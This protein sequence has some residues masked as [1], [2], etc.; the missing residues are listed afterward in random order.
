MKDY[1][2]PVDRFLAA[3]TEAQERARSHAE[4]L[5]PMTPSE[6]AIPRQAQQAMYDQ[7]YRPLL[8]QGDVPGALR[9]VAMQ[10]PVGTDPRREL[11][12]LM[13]EFDTPRLERGGGQ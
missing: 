4:Q 12:R 7:F 9:L 2:S 11:D 3:A 1:A 10:A 5:K 8:E 6:P 13:R